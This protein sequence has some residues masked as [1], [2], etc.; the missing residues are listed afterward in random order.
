ME[1]A[2]GRLSPASDIFKMKIGDQLLGPMTT[3]ATVLT[4]FSSHEA[5]SVCGQ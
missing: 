1:V 2:T 3:V 4:F 5:D